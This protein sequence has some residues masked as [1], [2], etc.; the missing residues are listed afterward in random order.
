MKRKTETMAGPPPAAWRG[1]RLLATCALLAL[2]GL[3]AS[4][5]TP[6][7][8][9]WAQHQ[10]TQLQSRSQAA[11][12]PL[13]LAQ[14][15]ADTSTD[16]QALAIAVAPTDLPTQLAQLGAVAQSDLVANK[17]CTADF[18]ASAGNAFA[19]S[20]STVIAQPLTPKQFTD[21]SN[22]LTTSHFAVKH[23]YQDITD[24]EL[25]WHTLVRTDMVE[26]YLARTPISAQDAALLATQ[27][28]Q[29]VGVA[30]STLLVGFGGDLAA[31][32]LAAA[33]NYFDQHLTNEMNDPVL[34]W[35]KRPFTD[36]EMTSLKQQTADSVSNAVATWRANPHLSGMLM[37]VNIL[38]DLEFRI[39]KVDYTA[40]TLSLDLMAQMDQ[41]R[42]SG[43]A[44]KES[45]LTMPIE[46]LILRRFV[47]PMALVLLLVVS[48][49]ALLTPGAAKADCGPGYKVSL[50]TSW[51]NSPANGSGLIVHGGVVYGGYSISIS[52]GSVYVQVGAARVVDLRGVP[53]AHLETVEGCSAWCGYPTVVMPGTYMNPPAEPTSPS[54]PPPGPP[55]RSPPVPTPATMLTARRTCAPLPTAPTTFTLAPPGVIA[56]ISLP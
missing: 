43:L 18:A 8:R 21:I 39:R 17:R 36:D 46:Q 4:A 20:L 22:S 24:L 54:R 51:S 15:D 48:G 34:P 37:A 38:N 10:V 52:N 16:A 53:I 25:Q 14:L 27:V 41:A 55:V 50:A 9:Q 40:P 2:A 29:L 7:M 30:D 26:R 23:P 31:D 1:R 3:T 5:A 56:T 47:P 12:K 35:L 19:A 28:D 45:Y 13:Q 33:V 6:T 11:G 32:D 44:A 49:F 42:C